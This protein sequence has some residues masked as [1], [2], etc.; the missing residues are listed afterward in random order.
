MTKR[1]FISKYKITML[2]NTQGNVDICYTTE[3][4]INIMHRTQSK[5]SRTIR[6]PTKAKEIILYSVN[7]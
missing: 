6:N 1:Y 5:R 3:K 4:G 7:H 2:T